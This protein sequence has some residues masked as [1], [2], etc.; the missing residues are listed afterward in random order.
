MDRSKISRLLGCCGR[1]A[2][3][4]ID[5]QLRRSGHD[6]TPVQSHALLYLSKHCDE[7]VT[8]RDLERALHL[9]PSTINGV[10]E[11]LLEKNYITRCPSPM[12]GRCRLL[13]LT[14]TGEQLIDSFCSALEQTDQRIL[15]HLTEEEKIVLEELLLRIIKNLENEADST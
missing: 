7:N 9:K 6:I 5:L 15:S 3:V 2:K 13:H 8:Q 10:V 11:R 4:H 12:D 14:E 1:L